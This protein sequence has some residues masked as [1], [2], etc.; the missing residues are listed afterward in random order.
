MHNYFIDG[1]S[2]GIA[3][4]INPISDLRNF[5]IV[6]DPSGNFR[7]Q[8]ISNLQVLKYTN[9]V[10]KKSPDMLAMKVKG[11]TAFFNGSNES[12]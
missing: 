7:F 2:D 11:K 5:T 9:I 12:T 1:P 10:K 3:L 8:N 6:V 4:N